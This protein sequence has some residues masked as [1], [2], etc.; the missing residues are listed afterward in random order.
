MSAGE[1]TNRVCTD[2]EKEIY[3]NKVDYTIMKIGK[4]E[5]DSVGGRLGIQER[6]GCS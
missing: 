5:T 3:Y 2:I 6:L 4:F 1:Q